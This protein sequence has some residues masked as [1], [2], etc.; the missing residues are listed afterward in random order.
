MLRE[1]RGGGGSCT[2]W[3]AE[4]WEILGLEETL[5]MFPDLSVHKFRVHCSFFIILIDRKKD[6]LKKKNQV[7]EHTPSHFTSWTE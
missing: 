1:N 2:S 4:M 6:F 7:V 3:I 5:A